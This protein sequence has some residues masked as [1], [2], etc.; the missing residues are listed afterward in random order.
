LVEERDCRLRKDGGRE[1]E[2]GESVRVR[3]CRR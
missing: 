2:K 3:V 1:G